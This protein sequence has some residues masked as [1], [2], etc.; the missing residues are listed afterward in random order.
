MES[1]LPLRK[2]IGHT[3]V[4]TTSTLNSAPPAGKN[5]PHQRH[6]RGFLR[7]LGLFERQFRSLKGNS[8]LSLSG[9]CGFFYLQWRVVLLCEK[10]W[11][12]GFFDRGFVF[13]PVNK[14]RCSKDSSPE[15]T[16]HPS[17]PNTSW[18]G[19]LGRFW[20]PNASSQGVWKARVMRFLP[21]SFQNTRREFTEFRE[22]TNLRRKISWKITDWIWL[23]LIG[24]ILHLRLCNKSSGTS[25]MNE[26]SNWFLENDDLPGSHVHLNLYFWVVEFHK[27]HFPNHSSKPMLVCLKISSKPQNIYF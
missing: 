4:I 9:N 1:H 20:G 26:D 5:C 2:K 7:D 12:V 10:N 14:C 21:W 22:F 3:E 15:K 6:R 17:L 19:V 13:F 18:E 11:R 25:I 16:L 23:D 8:Y 24:K 27:F